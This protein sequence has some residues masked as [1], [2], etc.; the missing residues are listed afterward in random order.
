VLVFTVI[1]FVVCLVG[2]ILYLV[3]ANLFIQLS[4]YF[5]GDKP[6]ALTA[7]QLVID[8]LLLFAAPVFLWVGYEL[9]LR[10][11]RRRIPG[12]GSVTRGLS[13]LQ[14]QTPAWF[15][16]VVFLCSAL[17]ALVAIVG[18]G[19]EDHLSSWLDYSA[20]IHARERLLQNVGFVG[21]VDIYT[22]LPL[23][24]AWAV[25]TVTA[26]GLRGVLLRGWPV[27]V[28][29]AVDLLVFQK[30]S[31]IASLLIILFA[32]LAAGGLRFSRRR[33]R[34]ALAGVG[35]VVIVYFAGVL[36]PVQ[37][38][39]RLCGIQHITCDV[40]TRNVPPVVLY[41]AMAP[42]TRTSVPALYYP[43]IYPAHHSFYGPDFG[44][45]IVGVGRYPDDNV[46]VWQY[47]NGA[48]AGNTAVPFQFTLYS[49][50]G[51]A[52]ALLASPLIGAVLALGWRLV[53]SR[54]LP[55]AWSGLLGAM[56]LIFA[57]FLAEDSL[58][59]SVLVSYGVLYG[60]LFLAAMAVA[61]HVL[62]L[63]A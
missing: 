50:D 58:R 28:T 9:A 34:L 31:A 15:P 25:V 41:A 4:E 20:G 51:I 32:W 19:A 40:I 53:R 54:R 26:N 16:T 14:L 47:I 46:V 33:V 45:D 61:V 12:A 57:A 43:V 6:P 39:G 55:R 24:A 49:E 37:A 42:F 7:A 63:R 17:L 35:A 5:T 27:V 36:A 18:S 48:T 56:V 30:R 23:T 44:Q 1:Y 52:G 8:L 60:L 59:N 10:V 38:H 13:S 29:I 2:A 11:P 62:N 22:I 21:F 3:G